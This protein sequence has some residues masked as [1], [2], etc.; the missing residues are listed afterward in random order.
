MTYAELVAAISDYTENTFPTASIDT[1]IQQAE[2]RIYNAVQ[3]PIARKNVTVQ[4][5]ASDAYLSCPDDFLAV[6]AIAVVDGTGVYEFLIN[7]DATFIRSAYPSPAATGMPRYYALFGPTMAGSPTPAPTKE[8]R[9]ILAPTPNIVYSVDL[10][11]YYY[12][13]SIT[14]GNVAGNTTWLSENLDSVLLY[15]S[16]VEAYTYMKGEADVLALYDAKY[17]EALMMA[18]RLGDGLE[19]R[20]SYRNGQIRVPVT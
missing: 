16:L 15:G 4:T 13:P 9:F 5:T 1:F 7:K 17:K 3:F 10:Q 12:P 6:Y 11:Y 18:K 20:D 19:G 8:L 2:Q 14:V